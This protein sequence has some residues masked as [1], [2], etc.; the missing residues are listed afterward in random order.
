MSEEITALTKALTGVWS[1]VREG[2]SATARFRRVTFYRDA[3]F[4]VKTVD[5]LST[6]NGHWQIRA[7]ERA[8]RASIAQAETHEPHDALSARLVLAFD[9]GTG[10]SGNYRVRMAT[11]PLGPMTWED[12]EAPGSLIGLARA[13]AVD[14]A[15]AGSWIATDSS[16]GLL[17][18]ELRADGHYVMQASGGIVR[19]G[20]WEFDRG[21][22]A[23]RGMA[24]LE[25]A[26]RLDP[27]DRVLP[28]ETWRA[29]LREGK[30]LSL[31]GRD[32][33]G[34]L[35]LVRRTIDSWSRQFVGTW[36]FIG[37]SAAP[38]P[39]E[40]SLRANG[41]LE[42]LTR[43]GGVRGHGRWTLGSLRRHPHALEGALALEVQS[44]GRPSVREQWRVQLEYESEF[45]LRIF[46][47]DGKHALRYRRLFR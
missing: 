24:L 10:P 11:P 6:L 45:E 28:V 15:L 33:P 8:S 39:H 22:A 19:I 26:L 1:V 31:E 12:A 46:S 17:A 38:V 25:G 37:P 32:L 29:S 5:G 3:R 7:L 18:L 41:S 2:A 16:R 21:Y 13:G 9:R 40:I 43:A 42:I 14:A 20:T 27:F 44:A 35:R 30:M 34:T 4:G 23:S 47:P 36:R